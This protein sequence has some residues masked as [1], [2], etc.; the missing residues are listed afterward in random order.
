MRS[1]TS[2]EIILASYPKKSS[3]PQTMPI[4][5]SR[6]E[7]VVHT[8]IRRKKT[9]IS[10]AVSITVVALILATSHLLPAHQVIGKD[11]YDISVHL[12]TLD[13]IVYVAN[14]GSN[15]VSVI[16]GVTTNI[17]VG[18]YPNDLSVN[19]STNTVYAANRDNNE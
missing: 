1:E 12:Y 8:G 3:S 2:G 15:T 9:K 6:S 17:P 5:N 19:P 18:T 4:P 13:N 7:A 14:S 16:N 11:P 10:I